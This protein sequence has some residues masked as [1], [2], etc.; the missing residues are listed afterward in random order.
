M[1]AFYEQTTT[2]QV[3]QSITVKTEAPDCLYVCTLS[4]ADKGEACRYCG[5]ATGSGHG[6]ARL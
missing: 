2:V 3:G 6:K 4:D 5:Y 1:E